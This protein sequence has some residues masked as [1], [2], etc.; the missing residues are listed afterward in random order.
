LTQGDEENRTE[1][2]VWQ[3]AASLAL[4]ILS[5]VDNLQDSVEKWKFP[6]E[7]LK[8]SFLNIK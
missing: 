5:P 2:Y 6:N 4:D 7:W 1:N 3:L 8:K